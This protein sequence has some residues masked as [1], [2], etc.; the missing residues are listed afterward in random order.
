MTINAIILQSIISHNLYI[1]VYLNTFAST[2]FSLFSYLFLISHYQSSKIMNW[3]NISVTI[4]L[5]HVKLLAALMRVS[6][7]LNPH[8]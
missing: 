4:D 2:S 1:N 6:L 3:L 5:L 8:Q 7:T